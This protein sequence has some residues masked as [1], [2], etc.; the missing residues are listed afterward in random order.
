MNEL[1]IEKLRNGM[2]A[3]DLY[4]ETMND[5][6]AAMKKVSDEKTAAVATKKRNEKLLKARASLI[7]A[8]DL[9][10]QWMGQNP[11]S[12]EDAK[13]LEKSIQEL[14]D[15][16]QQV[17]EYSDDGLADFLSAFNA[18]TGYKAENDFALLKMLQEQGLV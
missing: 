1:F 18:G 13:K 11:L 5:L 10:G 16:I 6:S 12:D 8:L 9:Y 17:F 15:L 4:K 3:E 14:E 7:S 2:S